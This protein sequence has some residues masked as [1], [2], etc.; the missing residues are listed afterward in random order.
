LDSY[1]LM[2]SIVNGL[3]EA[4]INSARLR[5][6][7]ET[8][9]DRNQIITFDERLQPI[10]LMSLINISVQRIERGM[11]VV[12]RQSPS[13]Q[14]EFTPLVQA[15]VISSDILLEAM[16][17][18]SDGKQTLQANDLLAKSDRAIGAQLQLHTSAAIQLDQL[19]AS[20][21]AEFISKKYQVRLFSWLVVGAVLV[22]FAAFSRN[23]LQRR[24][25]ERQL[26]VQYAIA[27]ILSE[28]LTLTEAT[29]QVLRTI[30]QALLWNRGE[31]WLL[32]PDK[33]LHLAGSWSDADLERSQ[34]ERQS[35]S[36]TF[37]PGVGLVGRVW[38]SGESLWLGDVA[39]EQ[40][41]LRTF[42]A[43]AL[44]L[45]SAFGFPV[46]SGDHVIGVL[47][48]FSRK[49]RKPDAALLDMM[50]TVGNQIGQFMKRRQ[51]EKALQGV[52][53]GVSAAT[54]AA[55]FQSLVKNLTAVLDVDYA[56]V[57]KLT[58]G[59]VS[60]VAICH[61]S[62]IIDNIEYELPQPDCLDATDCPLDPFTPGLP[63]RI[64]DS[65]QGIQSY[66]DT[67]LSSSGGKPLGVLAI[68]SRRPIADRALAE[69]ML[70][71]F[72]NRAAAELERQQAEAILREREGLLRMSLNAAHMGAWERNLLTNEGKWSREVARIFGL[73]PE[74]ATA[75]DF[76]SSIHPDDWPLLEEARR[77]AVEED[78]EYNVEFRICCPDGST[79][80]VNS[81]GNVIRDLDG[82]ALLLTGV[83][84]DI[85][86]RKHA[87]IALQQAEE[88]YRSIFENAVDGIFQTT[89]N[90]GFVSAN[91]A[92]AKIYGYDSAADL[93]ENLS[94]QIHQQ[95]YVQLDRR[96]EFI[97][98]IESHG[99]VVD[100]ESEIYRRDGR[101]IWISENARTVRDQQGN[102]LYYEGIVKDISDRKQAAADLFQAK[103]SA[104]AASRAKSQFLANMSHELRTP[105]NA[106]IGYSE[107]L[108]EEAE[109]SDYGDLVPDL[110]K[111]H[112]AGKHL[113]NLINDILD[114]SKIEA[115]KMD[116]YL[117]TFSLP[118]LLGEVES[119]LQPLVQ[120]NHNRLQVTWAEGLDTMYADLTKVRQI[121]L[122]LLSNA[123]KFTE[124]GVVKLTVD[125]ASDAIDDPS[126]IFR[127]SDTGIGMTPEQTAQLFQPFTQ[128]DA[129]TTRKYGGTG[130]GLAISRH[131]CHMM[132]GDIQ[133]TSNLG[134]GSTFTVQL[135]LA[136]KD[137]KL[138]V[139][140]TESNL[141][142]SSLATIVNGAT[143][144]VIDD[145]ARVRDLMV[146]YLTKEGFRVETAASGEE[147]LHLARSLRPDA[148][149]LDVMMPKMDGWSVLSALK[150]DPELAD[151]PVVVLT[152]V[153][154][155][156]LGFALGASD[157]V[158]KPVD[159]RR[160]AT[161]LQKYRPRSDGEPT[162]RVLIVE[163]DLVTREMFY[164]ILAREGWNVAE[165]ENGRAALAKVSERKPDLILL[166][167]MMPEMDGFQFIHELRRRSDCR[168]I[169]I[170]VITAI[171]LTPAD[172]LRLNG[173]VEQIL[174][175]GSYNRDELLRQVRDLVTTCIQQRPQGGKH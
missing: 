120:K 125:R 54:G 56:L 47:T 16:R 67:P 65:L 98:L 175:K 49:I 45:H 29:P 19:L 139:P 36:L 104:E 122:N 94:Y 157:Y 113:L 83:T 44:G 14:T 155:K 103:E 34:V 50:T 27:Q 76:F 167:L 163:D 123:A 101:I 6:L 80:W 71:I 8:I 87:E 90:G 75:A 48:F 9:A 148:I 135:P 117:E 171:D 161:L 121:L 96:S 126:L 5:D 37:A 97:A 149:T 129:S 145:D 32:N 110:Q 152:I 55:F 62:T 89:P 142:A 172:Q 59:K 100:F 132:G 46:R 13:L 53:Q 118:M 107:M 92:L 51:A 109:E 164:R 116:L 61:E 144:L 160:L 91:A 30:C 137:Q 174:Q 173:Y 124:N 12:Y 74:T 3:P 40:E 138:E 42:N 165:A 17:R 112:G 26:R 4:L 57:G 170:I 41:F 140:A 22:I 105:L 39:T 134:Q 86:D 168:E 1:Y 10:A 127:V 147:G 64:P 20:D 63:D 114:I 153:D 119:T 77:H 108:Q 169:P 78:A 68:M 154:N 70:K 58:T 18:N 141:T 159:Y 24:Q 52:A 82:S 128:A 21:I 115:G 66:M 85:S 72:A 79:R 88:K 106:I 60:T 156:N 95:L 136:V 81:Q 166:D 143:I 11:E 69:S 25:I 15:V 130:L 151:T 162:G 23:L 31:L 99:A 43:I 146:R 111:I 2:D 133:V 33:Q 7:A 28:A 158:T 93:I 102:I 38:S 84:R 131:F 35:R 73:D 150:A